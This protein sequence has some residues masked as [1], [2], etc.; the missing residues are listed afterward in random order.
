MFSCTLFVIYLVGFQGQ[1]CL[2]LCFLHD[3]PYISLAHMDAYFSINKVLPP[4]W[5]RIIKN[6]NSDQSLLHL[7]AK[8]ALQPSSYLRRIIHIE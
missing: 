8:H 4:S 5:L 6:W 2:H 3:F 1:T 7:L